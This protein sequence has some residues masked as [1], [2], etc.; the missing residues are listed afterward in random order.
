MAADATTVPEFEDAMKE[1]KELDER[2]VDWLAD[3]PPSQWS[4]SHFATFS[5]CDMILNNLCESFNR[6]ILDARDMP[7]LPML[8]WIRRYL[9]SRLAKRRE[10]A[11]R[12][13][14]NMQFCPKIV[15]IMEKN[16]R[17]ASS[18]VPVKADDWTYEVGCSDGS[19]FVVDILKKSCGC[20]K[21][22]LYG[23][24]CR[25]GMSAICGQQL[26]L[27]DFVDEV[28]SVENFKRVYS[29]SIGPMNGAQLWPK[30]GLPPPFPPIVKR[31]AGRPKTTRRRDPYEIMEKGYTR[32][33]KGDN[34][35]LP[36]QRRRVTC[37]FCGLIG[38]TLRGYQQRK[39]QLYESN[40]TARITQASEHEEPQRVQAPTTKLTV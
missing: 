40:S 11:L 36:K 15:K 38:H 6:I 16:I 18:C 30:T 5:K 24:P 20:R 35:S 9:L 14:E 25:H 34:N 23:I 3:K 12:K 28:Y 32:R 17:E 2:C 27:A 7:I 29:Y 39:A 26:D 10:M 8:E 19:R 22:D 31:S 33:Q 13:W 4:R 1:I 37:K 21:W